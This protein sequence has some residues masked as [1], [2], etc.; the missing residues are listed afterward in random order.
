MPRGS[1]VLAHVSRPVGDDAAA[2]VA[3]PGVA[4][5]Q[6]RGGHRGVAGIAPLRS[7]SRAIRAAAA[8]YREFLRQIERDGYGARPGR[9]GR[10]PPPQVAIA[11]RRGFVA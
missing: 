9:A 2:L 3:V 8:M 7:G 1:E 6:G 4:A 5:V 11:L 10:L